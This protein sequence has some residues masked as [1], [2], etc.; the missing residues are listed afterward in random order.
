MKEDGNVVRK[1]IS[2]LVNAIA[3]ACA[4]SAIAQYFSQTKRSPIRYGTRLVNTATNNPKTEDTGIDLGRQW[5]IS[6]TPNGTL[7]ERKS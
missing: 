1:L 7:R 3:Q 2:T 4:A 5:L 6:D